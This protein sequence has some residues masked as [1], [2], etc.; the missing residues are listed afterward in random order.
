MNN[1][2]PNE[3]QLGTRRTPVID[4]K[5]IFTVPTGEE[6]NNKYQ[7]WGIEEFW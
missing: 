7:G 3:K 1:T 5:L 4:P 6:A 2:F